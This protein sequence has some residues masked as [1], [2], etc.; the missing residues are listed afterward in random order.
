[1]VLFISSNYNSI[2]SIFLSIYSTPSIA[3]GYVG[4]GG[5]FDLASGFPAANLF[6]DT[7]LKS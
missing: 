5:D 4:Y 7:W 1:M 2:A 3:W 6:C